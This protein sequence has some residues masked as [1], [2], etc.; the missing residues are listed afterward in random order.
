MVVPRNLAP[1]LYLLHTEIEVGR[2]DERVDGA[3][4]V[5]SIRPPPVLRVVAEEES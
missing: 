3:G 2:L 5:Q 1:D 4:W